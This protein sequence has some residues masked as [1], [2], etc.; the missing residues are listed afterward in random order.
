MK[1]ET[2]LLE[3]IKKKKEDKKAAI[4]VSMEHR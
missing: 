4:T 2:P 1:V 3:Y